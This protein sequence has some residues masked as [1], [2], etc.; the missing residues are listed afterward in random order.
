MLI[1]SSTG[2]I[3]KNIKLYFE[4]K[5]YNIF[6][7][8]RTDV[9][10]KNKELLSDSIKNIDPEI[11]I[12]CCG[13]VGSSIRNELLNEDDI[14]NDNIL[15]NI[16]ILESCKNLN[17]KKII[18]MSSYRVFGENVCENYDDDMIQKSDIKYNIGYLTSKK[19][20]DIQIK[21]F[22]KICKIDVICLIL[23]N[24]YGENDDFSVDS[25]IVP[26]LITKIKKSCQDNT[27]II[28]NGNKNTLVNLVFIE[29]L[30]IIIENCIFNKNNDLSGNI[31][32]FNKNG[33]ISIEKLVDI[34]CK[35]MNNKNSIKYTSEEN[36]NNKYIMKPNLDKFNKY[37]GDFE[38]HEIEKTIEL[39]IKSIE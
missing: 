22:M 36:I 27:D 15:L 1:V 6:C 23:T 19:V 11:V 21:L 10:F 24:I 18:M 12:N 34:I 29:D 17:I 35:I 2:F 39:I 5:K 20:L 14:L 28:I 9:D 13:I 32:L 26:S 38:F 25:R 7:L 4:K 30:S 3:G 16:N 33:I 8:N 31:I 37:F